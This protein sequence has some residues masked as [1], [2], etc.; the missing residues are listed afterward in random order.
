MGMCEF[1]KLIPA[2]LL[3]IRGERE[4]SWRRAVLE[5]GV[6]V[7]VLRRQLGDIRAC[8]PMADSLLTVE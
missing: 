1:N 8:T 4:L 3:E 7:P 5:T 6:V 2:L